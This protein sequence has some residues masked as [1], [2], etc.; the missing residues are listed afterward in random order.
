MHKLTSWILGEESVIRRLP[1]RPPEIRQPSYL[2]QFDDRTLIYD[3]F[4][5]PSGRHAVLIGPPLHNLTPL[6]DQ[7]AVTNPETGAPLAFSIAH[8]D[9]N[10]QIWIEC[11][12]AAQRLRL[13]GLPR[14]S[15]DLPLQPNH[16]DLFAGRRV[17]VTMSKD[18]ELAW[19][20]DWAR[21]HQR[22]HGAE[23]FLLYD[24]ASTKYS[25][26][27]IQDT[28]DRAAPGARCVV[29][30]WPFKFGPHG[31][32]ALVWDS[33]Y[34]IY[35]MIE[36]AR[37]RYLAQARCVLRIDVDEFVISPNRASVFASTEASPLGYL[38]FVGC[39]IVNEHA[40]TRLARHRDFKYR[41]RT[42][43]ATKNWCVAPQ[44]CTFEQQWRN[45]AILGFPEQL[46]SED[47]FMHRHFKAI[48]TSWKFQ[49]FHPVAIDP[50]L[51]VVD[52]VLVEQLAE[53]LG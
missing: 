25:L 24:N 21:F 23:G 13:S 31:G 27:D 51:H 6:F 10:A 38:Q 26:A 18:N 40:A 36:H 35:G 12:S 14:G 3:A 41:E 4:R 29:V 53:F 22:A 17:V 30:S 34:C 37:W 43:T 7:M 32:P 42:P 44:R 45:H 47:R 15:R 39:W 49:R 46:V 52:H 9:R 28:L 5:D 48:N 1:P 33:D 20:F 8:W 19:I 2:E 50:K 11:G 16:A